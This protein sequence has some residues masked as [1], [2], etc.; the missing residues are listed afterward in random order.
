MQKLSFNFCCLFVRTG[1]S[2]GENMSFPHKHK[3]TCDIGV[4][5]LW[6]NVSAED[7]LM[8]EKSFP[9]KDKHTS[10]ASDN[11]FYCFRYCAPPLG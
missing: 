3:N 4:S 1:R 2:C 10:A 8:G 7:D 9:H 6:G 11:S 5:S